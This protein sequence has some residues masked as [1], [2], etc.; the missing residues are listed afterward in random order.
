M[1]AVSRAKSIAA[2]GL[3]DGAGVLEL[4]GERRTCGY[5]A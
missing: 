5:D 4:K 2:R 3:L 1:I